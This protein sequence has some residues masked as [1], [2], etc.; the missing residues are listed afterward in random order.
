MHND[1]LQIICPFPVRDR[2]YDRWDWGISLYTSGLAPNH[3]SE[4]FPGH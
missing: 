4:T 1:N 2:G 3:E